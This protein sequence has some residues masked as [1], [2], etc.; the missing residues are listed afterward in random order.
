MEI[1]KLDSNIIG[2]TCSENE[3]VERCAH[4]EF[5]N[6]SKCEAG[7][8]E[9]LKPSAKR[10]IIIGG[11]SAVRKSLI[12]RGW[13]EEVNPD[14]YDFDFKWALKSSDIDFGRLKSHQIVNHFQKNR[15]LTTKVNYSYRI[16]FKF[17]AAQTNLFDSVKQGKR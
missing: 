16:Y 5:D 15:S 3:P 4:E 14:S 13:D 9:A 12:E 2:N 6:I 10:F 11:F 8:S 17:S 7:A 1:E